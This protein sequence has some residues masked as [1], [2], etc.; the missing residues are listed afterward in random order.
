LLNRLFWTELCER[1]DFD[2]NRVNGYR[3][4][5]VSVSHPILGRE[6]ENTDL[7]ESDGLG[8]VFMFN[9]QDWLIGHE[10]LYIDRAHYLLTFDEESLTAIVQ[11]NEMTND[12][13][14]KLVSLA[15]NTPELTQKYGFEPT[16]EA[17]NWICSVASEHAEPDDFDA[18][19]KLNTAFPELLTWRNLPTDKQKAIF[20]LLS[21]GVQ[22]P[23]SKLRND[24]IHFLGC[25]ALHENTPQELL[26]ELDKL[27]I[28]LVTEVLENRK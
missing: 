1:G 7:E 14:A 15:M 24:A 11:E 20:D 5:N 6:F 9:D 22:E 10:E 27:K 16:D 12:L 13:G 26:N 23:D 21:L 28:P 2:I 17:E 8:G 3:V 18:S 4:D 25:M 19:A